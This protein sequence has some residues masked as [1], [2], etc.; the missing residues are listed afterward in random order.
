MKYSG[1]S[2]R[3]IKQI[4]FYVNRYYSEKNIKDHAPIAGLSFDVIHNHI[5]V[6]GTYEKL[7]LDIISEFLDKKMKKFDIALDVGANIGNHTVRLFA[8]KF[9]KVYCYEPNEVVFDLLSVNTKSLSNVVCFKFGLSDRNAELD[10]KEN[11][12]NIGASF[13][14]QNKI[15]HSSDGVYKKVQ[16]RLLDEEQINGT[17][18]LIKVDIEGHEICFLKGAVETITRDKP[19]ILFEEGL[20]NE[21]GGPEVIDYLRDL[22][23]EF[24]TINEN[25]YFGDSKIRRLA[26]YLFQ[27]FL[28]IKVKIVKTEKFNKRFYHLIIAT[29][30]D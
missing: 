5:N 7:E 12:T 4:L 27:D 13:I 2:K 24:F 29:P 10:F 11:K 26:R 21:N 28:G 19:I 25:F 17:V 8:K 30:K 18:N 14:T 22:E 20:I 3:F 16:V 9:D 15:S 6:F 23:Y 1:S